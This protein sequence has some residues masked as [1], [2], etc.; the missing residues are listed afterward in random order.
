MIQRLRR[1][2][3]LVLLCVELAFV[4]A[5]LTGLYFNARTGFIHMST[6]AMRMAARRGITVQEA[7]SPRDNPARNEALPE[8]RDNADAVP[9]A[10]L[11]AD[12][13]GALSLVQ[14]Q[15]S[16][17]D[18]QTLFAQA[19]RALALEADDGLLRDANLRYLRMRIP[20]GGTRIVL[21]S[22]A[23]EQALLRNQAF[24]SLL[25]LLVCAGLFWVI[26]MLLSRMLV[27]PVADA[28]ARERQF[29]ADASH[30][31]K[32]PLT[33]V[34]SNAE[35]LLSSGV[36]TD[37]RSLR[38]LDN[39]RAESRR[40]RALVEDLLSLARLDTG[41]IAAA[42]TPQPL[43]YITACALSS[44]EPAIFDAG[45]H[46]SESIAENLQVRGDA[47]QLRELLDILLDNACK[48]S[49]P[50]STIRVTLTATHKE[51]ALCV[52][53]AGEPIP[54]RER[55]AI[56]R[57]FYQRDPSRSQQPGY[58]LG[59]SIAQ[60]IVSEHGGRI[61]VRSDTP[62]SNTFFVHLPLCTAEYADE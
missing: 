34:L 42:H 52:T 23:L 55:S 17:L 7:P 30:E 20:G 62:D 44:F 56:F 26:S 48:Y 58:G 36:I 33:V 29:I 15:I 40:M 60:S 39:I 19:R 27:R 31:L 35:M 24:L 32:T 8:W 49:A 50:D 1:K 28:F 37:E 18:E 3:V 47:A 9:L 54:P 51:A 38:R 22:T 10:V 5:I 43:S 11:T 6:N 2:I 53:S 46:L 59:L 12:A 13:Q 25:I 14:N 45:R 57:R 41:K 16:A 61:G 21:A 4:L